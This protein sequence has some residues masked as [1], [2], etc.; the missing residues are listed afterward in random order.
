M[1]DVLSTVEGKMAKLKTIFYFFFNSSFQIGKRN[2]K[3]NISVCFHILHYLALTMFLFF[4]SALHTVTTRVFNF[5]GTR[6]S[7]CGILCNFKGT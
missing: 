5:L 3:G 1:P 6:S 2:K 7:H 4:C